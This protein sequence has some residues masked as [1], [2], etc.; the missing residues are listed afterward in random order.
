MLSGS[1]SN[2]KNAQTGVFIYPQFFQK[3]D[4]EES[5]YNQKQ[6]VRKL[7]FERVAVMESQHDKL[8]VY[9]VGPITGYAFEEVAQW[10][11]EFCANPPEGTIGIDPLRK[12][13]ELATSAV[14]AGEYPTH[15][16]ASKDGILAQNKYDVMRSNVI[17]ANFLGKKRR[18]LGSDI[19]FAWAFFA[20]KRI[21]VAMEEGNPHDHPYVRRCADV[22]VGTIDEA[23][24]A[25][26][27]PFDVAVSRSRDWE[28]QSMCEAVGREDIVLIDLASAS[29]VS[30]PTIMKLAWANALGK[31]VV[32]ALPDNLPHG[33]LRGH[34]LIRAC[35]PFVTNNRAEAEQLVADLRAHHD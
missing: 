35:A 16:L 4:N 18:S 25:L 28:M 15:R 19:E 27:K 7:V 11:R 29:N 13:P 21:V 31:P 6:V 26:R 23:R 3:Q 5:W 12:R 1:K 14:I 9:L 33:D 34:P 22:V 20:W 32:L 2:I 30:I 17:F 10:R 24:A 8:K